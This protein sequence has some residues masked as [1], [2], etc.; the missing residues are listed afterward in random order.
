MRTAANI[1]AVCLALCTR[2]P[3]ICLCAVHAF[4]GPAEAED[5]H[6]ASRADLR[7]PPPVR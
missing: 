1:L 5:L 3:A 7:G 6:V 4:Q 2:S